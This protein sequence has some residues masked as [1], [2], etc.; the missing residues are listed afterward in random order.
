MIKY[1]FFVFSLFIAHLSFSQE[2]VD[3]LQETSLEEINNQ[4]DNPLSQFW[5][6]II[7]ENIQFK[8]GDFTNETYVSNVFNF[9]PSLPV[10]IGKS[11]MLLVRPVF[12]FLSSPTFDE[13]GNET[14]RDS[15]FGDMQV[16]SLFGPDKKGG[17]VW[18]AGL[19]FTFP[20]ASSEYLGSGKFQMGPALMLLSMGEKWVLGTIIQHWKSVSGASYRA[21]VSR[22]EIQYIIRKKIKGKAMTIGMGPS[23]IIDS[24]ATEGNRVTFP[25]GLG[26]TKTVKWGNTPWKLRLEPQYSIIKPDYYGT[27]WSIRIQFAPI[28]RNPFLSKR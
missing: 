20:T 3:E 17:L 28:I 5:S 7:Q 2:K 1:F 18:G 25:I 8:N 4:L 15:G 11:K 13:N 10:P 12:P 27:L 26:I 6:L 22:T 23:I 14:G 19:T 24:E 9:Q 16:F 21:D